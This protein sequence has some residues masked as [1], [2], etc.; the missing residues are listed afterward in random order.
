LTVSRYREYAADRGSALLTGAP[1]ALM[2]A[3][4]KL[5]EAAIPSDDLRL[6]GAARAFCMCRRSAGGFELLMDHPPL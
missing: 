2:S 5:P 3:L 4:Q 1:Q 6:A